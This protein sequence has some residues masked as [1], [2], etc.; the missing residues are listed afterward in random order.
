MG[1][2]ER[3]KSLDR[4]EFAARARAARAY[5]NLSLDDVSGRLGISRQAL[6]RRENA[7]VDTP[8]PDRFVMAAVYN[9]V[10]GIPEEFFILPELTSLY[11][12]AA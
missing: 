7:K 4:A 8:V 2:M 11:R 9:E 3:F 6:S 10:A 1:K 5:A 12:N